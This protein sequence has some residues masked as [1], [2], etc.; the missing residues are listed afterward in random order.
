[1]RE[2]PVRPPPPED[3]QEGR[4]IYVTKAGQRYHLNQGCETLRGYRSY[5]KRACERCTEITQSVLTIDPNQSPPQSETELTFVYENENYHHKKCDRIRHTRRKGSKP[6]CLVCE[7]EERMLLWNR[8]AVQ[9][10]T[11]NN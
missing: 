4:K 6:I 7:S 11:G 1:V 9:R 8:A 2:E 10:G 5:E 3:E